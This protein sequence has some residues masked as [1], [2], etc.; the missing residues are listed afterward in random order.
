MFYL[1]FINVNFP[2]VYI[3]AL[4]ILGR[5]NTNFPMKDLTLNDN[6]SNSGYTAF[7]VVKEPIREASNIDFV[8]EKRH[9]DVLLDTSTP[10]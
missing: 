5:S 9:M 10:P 3:A 8:H 7:Q 2:L 4:I 1:I 6:K